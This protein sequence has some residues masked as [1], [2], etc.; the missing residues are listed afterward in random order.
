M[1]LTSL[2]IPT[3]VALANT[4]YT[5]AELTANTELEA[6]FL[7]PAH[8]VR[9]AFIRDLWTAYTAGQTTLTYDFLT[10]T[11]AAQAA[12]YL[13]DSGTYNYT[14]TGPE[15][16]PSPTSEITVSWA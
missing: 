12:A 1:A 15:V 6:W 2:L 8:S 7:D 10:H 14:V 3:K 16:L 4:R 11:D 5:P 13:S 9:L